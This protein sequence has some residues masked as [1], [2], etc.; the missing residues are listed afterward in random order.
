MI[1]VLCDSTGFPAFSRL[2]EPGRT[3]NTL[4]YTSTWWISDQ[5]GALPV[6][7]P[8]SEKIILMDP[9]APSPSL[10]D[11][12]E[13]GIGLASWGAGGCNTDVLTADAKTI[14]TK[15]TKVTGFTG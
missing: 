2:V 10:S 11:V 7:S 3:W 9:V 4:L 5:R 1:L 13:Y 14:V 8:Y 15:K 12:W 6:W